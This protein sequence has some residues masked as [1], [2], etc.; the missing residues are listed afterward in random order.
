MVPPVPLD[1]TR[2]GPV[3]VAAMTGSCRMRALSAAS[4]TSIAGPRS[5]LMPDRS[6]V[7]LPLTRPP[8]GVVPAKLVSCRRLSLK[9]PRTVMADTSL[10]VSWLCTRRLSLASDPV[11]LGSASDPRSRA[12]TRNGPDMSNRS[13]AASRQ[14]DSAGPS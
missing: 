11:R 3:T 14:S 9:R 1:T 5:R 8:L 13:T 6:S 12:L 2:S 4:R 10:P 7:P